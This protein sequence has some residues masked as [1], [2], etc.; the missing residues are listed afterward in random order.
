LINT[1][2]TLLIAT[3]LAA[4]TTG[5]ASK[6][7]SFGES[8]KA[9]GQ[10]VASIGGKWEEGQSLVRK[11]NKHI[12]KG[13]GQIEDGNENVSEGCAMVKLM[14]ETENSYQLQAGE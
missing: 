8:V 2:R 5:C 12:R 6:A 1:I 7:P 10:A 9:E 13:N 3:L 14:D 4:I 11:G